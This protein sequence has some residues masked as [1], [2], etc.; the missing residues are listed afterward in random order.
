MEITTPKA[1]WG[2]W[3][4]LL[5]CSGPLAAEQPDVWQTLLVPKY[6]NGVEFGT[7]QGVIIVEAPA[8]TEDPALT[9]VTIKATTPQTPE[10]FLETLYVF[11]DNNPEPLAGIFNLDPALGRVEMSLRL[12][13]DRSSWVRAV[14]VSN[15]GHHYHVSQFI[16]SQGGGCSAPL[17]TD[18]KSAMQS[19]G[20]MK[21]RTLGRRTEDNLLVGH[22]NISH[23]NL[24]GM[25]FDQKLRVYRPA[26]YV[27][28]VLL[29]LDGETILDAQTGFALSQDP[30]FRFFFRP[31][32]GG[33]VK[34]IVEDTEGLS[35]TE[36]FE[37]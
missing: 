3:L 21:F 17:G 32:D 14:A 9:P 22:F 37:L 4:C 30:S 13:I 31:G 20:K 6:F 8:R 19:I 23:P 2:Q 7:E 5:A 10:R 29:T 35:F 24:T 25:Q 1:W 12:R 36:E 15:T 27:T 26:H 28:K 16:K 33:T 34:A 11:V 18:L